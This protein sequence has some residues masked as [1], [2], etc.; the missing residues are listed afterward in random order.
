MHNPRIYIIMGVAGAGKTTIGRM[1]ADTLN[2][3]FHDGDDYHSPSN[4]RKMQSG[5]PLDDADRTEW[6]TSLHLL[7]QDLVRARGGIIACSALKEKYRTILSAGIHPQVKW[8]FL[9]GGYDLIRQ[10]MEQ[11]QGHYMPIELLQSQFDI[12]E[13]PSGAITISVDQ[14]PEEIVSQ[15]MQHINASEIGI[16]GLGVMGRSLALN[17][18]EKGYRVSLFNR[19][20]PGKEEFVAKK[21]IEDNPGILSEAKGFESWIDFVASLALPRKIVL[22]VDAGPAVDAVLDA[23][24]PMLQSG[25]VV[26]DCGNSHYHD[27]HR[28]Q[29]SL[30]QKQVHYLGVGVSGGEKGARYGPSVMPGGNPEGYAEMK[31]LLES[32]AARDRHNNACCSYIGKA[33]AGHFVKMVHNGIEYA[34]MQLLAEAY[35]ILRHGLQY[36]PDQIAD[37]FHSWNEGIHN[38]FLIQLTE[39]ILRHR[40]GE[41]WVLDEISDITQ[42]KGTGGW[43]LQAANDL[44]VASPVIAAALHARFI[45]TMQSLA[46]IPGVAQPMQLEIGLLSKALWLARV[47]NHHFGFELLQA[48]SGKWQWDLNLQEIARIWTNGCI[49]R[50]FLMEQLA[51]TL[52]KSILVSFDDIETAYRSLISVVQESARTRL[53]IPCFSAALNALHTLMH[54]LPTGNLIQAQRDAFGAH[55]FLRSD[56]PS[57]TLHHYPWKSD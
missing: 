8:I 30:Q 44:G 19:H 1:L 10:R 9:S 25:D 12:L 36:S 42:S 49:I 2:L 47:V 35:G 39:N 48:A 50:S 54:H 46:S 24:L 21:L 31:A 13:K 22:M 15:I 29:L 28:R 33:G 55:G 53:H 14:S 6:L 57:G 17:F 32:I 52:P 41:G 40:S 4:R 26:A 37:C 56:D 16:I 34:E 38:G 11:R 20:V 45:T 18:A 5:I 7:A 3:P 51:E 23:I 27:T 43:T